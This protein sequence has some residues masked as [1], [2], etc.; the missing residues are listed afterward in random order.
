[1]EFCLNIVMKTLQG[2]EYEANWIVRVY[3]GDWYVRIIWIN[4]NLIIYQNIVQN[5]FIWEEAWIS[6][7]RP[8]NGCKNKC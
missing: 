6:K 8:E 4:L 3:W 2:N 7:C 1:M 5:I